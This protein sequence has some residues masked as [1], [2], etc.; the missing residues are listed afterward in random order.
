MQCQHEGCRVGIHVV[1]RYPTIVD[2]KHRDCPRPQLP[3]GS[4]HTPPPTADHHDPLALDDAFD[5]GR[6]QE[7]QMFHDEPGK[8][9]E[10]AQAT[11]SPN[12]GHRVMGPKIS[13]LETRRQYVPQALAI[14]LAHAPKIFFDDRK[15][16]CRGVGRRQ[17]WWFGIHNQ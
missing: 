16:R 9:V 12:P 6:L 10:A 17:G 15:A 8:L 4:T 7:F 3:P 14:P 1:L 5:L 11:E 2:A 13:K